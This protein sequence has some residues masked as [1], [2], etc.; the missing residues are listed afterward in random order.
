MPI[1][2]WTAEC[3][4]PYLLALGQRDFVGL[5]SVERETLVR[6]LTEIYR[7]D[8]DA[9]VHAA[10]RW[11]LCTRMSASVNL[12]SL[13]ASL[14]REANSARRWQ[15]GP[16][17]HTF[18]V[19]RGAQSFV[20]GSPATEIL[21]EADEAAHEQPIG[22]GFAI[23]TEEVT[24][25]QFQRFRERYV[26]RRYSP[27]DD[28][29]TNNVTWFEAAAYCRWLSEQ[30]ELPEDQ[31]CYPRAAEIAPGMKMPENWLERTGYRL[32]TEAEW[33]YACRG[34][35]AA[36]RYF[37]E[38]ELLRTR[39][40][41]FLQNS[42]NRAWPVGQLK[43]NNFGLFDM[44]GNVAERCQDAMATYPLNSA[45]ASDLSSR[46]AVKHRCNRHAGFPRRKLR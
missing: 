22:H 16:N 44:L 46:A 20:M 26:N 45:A 5:T 7:A 14:Q 36:S 21:R 35:V 31:M 40:A 4:R 19:F 10:C 18:V 27:T 12:F 2:P 23:S 39:Y 11:L 34:G 6:G 42:D 29:P 41:W 15:V 1:A 43:P 37:G 28:C 9:G 8:P 32:P 38:G 17:G 3:A 25:A 13:D 30:A 24:I 33:E